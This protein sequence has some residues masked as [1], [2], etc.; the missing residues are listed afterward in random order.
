MLPGNGGIPFRTTDLGFCSDSSE[1]IFTFSL[2]APVS[3]HHRL[4]LPFCGKVTLFVNAFL[5]YRYY[6]SHFLRCQ[7]GC[8]HCL[9]SFS[10]LLFR[11]LFHIIILRL[12]CVPILPERAG[13]SMENTQNTPKRSGGKISYTLQAIGLI[14]LLAL[15]IVMLFFTSQWFTKTMYQEVERELYDA[16]KSA[17]TLLNAAYPGDYRLEG[18]VAYL[19]YKGDVD[20][21][22]EYSLFD[23]FKEDT[24]LDIT[25]FYQDT[26]ILTTLYNAQGDRIVGSGAPDVVIRDV[27]NTGEDHFYINTLINGKTYFSYYSPVRNQDG[28]IVGMLFIGKSSAA[29]SQ[30]IQRYVYP[31]TWLIIGFVALVAVCIYFYTRRFVAVLLHIHSFLS[32]VASGN[33]NATLDHS[34]TKRS[35]ELGDIGRCALS[36]QRSLRTM[37]EQDALTEL[38][39]RRSG[40]KKLRQIF[41]EAQSSRH[42]FALAIGD[43]DFFKKVNDTYGHECGDAVLKNVSALLKQH[44][45]R[46]GFAARWGGEE[47]LLVFENV[48]LAE[49]RKQLELLMDKIHELDTLYEGQHVKINMTFGLVCESDKDV[50]TLLKEADEK[51]YIGKT[52]GR[53][54]VVS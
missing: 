20:I 3:H 26:R 47:F 4:A 24:G 5:I 46:R 49:A 30:S 21:T 13:N 28:S 40:E 43:I 53:N 31:L 32:E 27:L 38:Y 14:P 23:Q 2:L 35:D 52:N 9:E 15:G 25:L 22:R 48:D 10:F 50:H 11:H 41:E 12:I 1:V 19:L 39:N 18:D 37:I 33:L 45:W 42:S 51:L 6:I 8:Y 36:M 54:Q 7:A 34:V 44:M 29:V 17:T 16:T